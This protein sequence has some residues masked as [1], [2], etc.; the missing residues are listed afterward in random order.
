MA[1]AN[2]V[3]MGSG[4]ATRETRSATLRHWRE[5]M[6]YPAAQK[7]TPA[8]APVLRGMGIGVR[9]KPTRT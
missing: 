2:Q 4:A 8:S 5:A 3:A 6:G 9:L 7:I 1:M